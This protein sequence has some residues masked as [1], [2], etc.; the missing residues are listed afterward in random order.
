MYRL[1][2]HHWLQILEGSGK[3]DGPYRGSVFLGSD[4]SPISFADMIAACAETG[5]FGEGGLVEFT[6]TG[7]PAGK[8]VTSRRS[9]DILK[10][11]PKYSSFGAFMRETGAKDFYSP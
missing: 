3:E 7:G 9:K 10:W 5:K 6:E 4:D 8:M 2:Q 11:Q 1:K